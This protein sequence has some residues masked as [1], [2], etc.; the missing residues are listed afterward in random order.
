MVLAVLSF[1]IASFRKEK[2]ENELVIL[3]TLGWF[4]LWVGLSR[5]AV[6]SDFFVGM[7]LAYGTAWLLWLSPAH[8]IQKLK[9]MEIVHQ[10]TQDQLVT[11][12]VATIVLVLVLFWPPLGGHAQ[13]SVQTARMRSPVPGENSRA[14]AYKWMEGYA[15]TRIYHGC[16]LE[17]WHTTECPRQCRYNH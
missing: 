16:T 10:R 4:L 12:N 3:A 8:L 15:S 14:E 7:P 1:G 11:T 5:G 13:R 6:R 2:S 9:D 17:F